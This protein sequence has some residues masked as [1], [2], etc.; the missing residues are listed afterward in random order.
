[1]LFRRYL[2]IHTFMLSATIAAGFLGCSDDSSSSGSDA[3]AE[4]EAPAS[5]SGTEGTPVS[6]A[7]EPE[8][9]TT[10]LK[11]D[12]PTPDG[13][14]AGVFMGVCEKGP[15][16]AG[17]TVK[18]SFLSDGDLSATGKSVDA[19]ITDN[20]GNYTMQ[21]SGMES[22]GL[23]EASGKFLNE[24]SGDK[25]S[26]PITLHALVRAIDGDTA[27]INV[28]THLEYPRIMFLMKEKGMSYSDAQNQA[29]SEILK[30][31]HLKNFKVAAQNTS[32][33]GNSDADGNLLAASLLLTAENSSADMQAFLDAVAADIEKDGTWDD[34]DTKAK[35]ADW[36]YLQKMDELTYYLEDLADSKPLPSF[37]Q[38]FRTFWFET[39]GLGT[40]DSTKQG[41]LV[42]NSNE[43]SKYHAQTFTC[44]DTTWRI[45]SATAL[46]N[47]EGVAL[48]GECT[49]ALEGTL[50]ENDGKNF[51]CKKNNWVYASEAE[52]LN[53]AVTAK[54]G[55]CT[56][57]NS[58]TVSEHEQ[59]YV[60]C[61]NS[62]W[63]KLNAKPVDYSKGR[64]MN[65]KLG[66]GINLGN[67]WES[68]GQKGSS[69]D[70]GWGNCIKDEYF[71]V[72]KDAGFKSIRLPV[73]WSYD[74]A[75]DAPYK[76]D[77]GRLAGVKADIDIALAQGLVV[78]VNFHH[79]V[80]LNNYAVYY[81]N[82]PGGYDKEKARF[83]AM[84]EQVAKEM[85]SYGDDQIV[86]EILN[87]PHDMKNKF[88]D[89]LMLAAYEVIRK[90][91][92][93]K[94]IMFEGNGYSK[95]A[96]ISNVQLPEDGNII[97]SGHYYEPFSF[98]HQGHGYDCGT[99]LKDTDIS[100]IPG[101][102]KAYVDSAL[103]HFPDINGGHIPLNMGEFGVSGKYGSC[104]GN[105]PSDT[106]RAKWTDAAI[107]AAKSYGMSW[108]Y[109]GLV[110]VGGFEAYDKNAGQWYP[111]LLQV[112]SKYL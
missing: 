44:A 78:I 56:A 43:F 48:F 62:T 103:T 59:G 71:K 92:P 33:F 37:D 47:R 3:G 79:Y 34:A 73:R 49:E 65:E 100:K 9:T 41:I 105:G 67:A 95:F 94:T 15:F 61:L 101:Q 106:D 85:D 84:W 58:G 39:F 28:L 88:V 104:G 31:L 69:G 2:G 109:W 110:G 25:G 91:A 68:Q 8:D 1:M 108:Q 90:N 40:C 10:T 14:Y 83:L 12:V 38:K 21:Y 27:N 4:I 23:L 11:E 82:N 81:D 80:E 50:K 102:F 53:I 74:A 112:F 72:I 111:E 13:G 32:V 98:T 93:G 6:K 35:I 20:F 7:E 45:A 17:G 24:V 64:A 96:Q 70:C 22:L 77:A 54:N 26:A 87:E 63:K 52:L 36:A 18:L 5:S 66:A 30:A 60:L 29:E 107:K 46:Q 89:E 99:K 57:T 97:F 16:L 76:L 42:E 51:I 19:T 75:Q 86:L 55:A